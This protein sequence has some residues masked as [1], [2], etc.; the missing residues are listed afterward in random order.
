MESRKSQ[1]MTGTCYRIS[2][3]DVF[4]QVFFVANRESG[5]YSQIIA[6]KA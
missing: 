1:H 4:T 6:L 5:K 2:L 3:P